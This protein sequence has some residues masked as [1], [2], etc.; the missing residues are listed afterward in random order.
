M[1]HPSASKGNRGTN[2]VAFSYLK[3]SDGFSGSGNDRFLAG[4]NR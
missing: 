4:Y 2:R 1:V 3:S